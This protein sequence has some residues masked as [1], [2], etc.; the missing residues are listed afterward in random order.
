LGVTT[1]YDP[2][3]P[4]YLDE[5]DV[6]NELTRVFEVCHGCRRCVGYCGSFP[7]L[8]ELVDRL[9][10][11]DPGRLTPAEQDRVVDECFQCK[12]CHVN[13]PYTPDLHEWAIDFPRLML[14][15]EAMRHDT[16]QQP[17]RRRMTTQAM[18]RTDLVGALATRSTPLANAFAGAPTGSLRRKLIAAMTGVS[19]VRLLPTYARQRFST[20]FAQRTPDITGDRGQPVTVYPT[21]V[22]EYQEP[23]IGR[24]LVRVYERNG[25]ECRLSEAG[26]C[27]A[28]WLH[29]GDLD[30]FTKIARTNVATLAAEIRGGGEIVVSQPTCGYVLRRDYPDYVP[31]PDAELVAEHTVDAAEHLVRLHTDDL[32]DGRPGLDLA[33][34]GAVPERITYHAA[35]HLRAQEAAFTS[36]DLLRLVGAEVTTVRQCSGVDGMWGLRSENE[37]TAIPIA[38]RLAN[39]V[40]VAGD[41]PVAGDCHLANTAIAEQTGA[42]PSHPLS[43]I[44]RAYGIPES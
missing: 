37:G 14:R 20:W 32:S 36:G 39:Q 19:A 34:S 42:S 4:A 25:V 26:C 43:V 5:A 22:V 27:G 1:T 18:A 12:L 31:G 15:T 9:D 28:P 8:F 17:L 35:C 38:E 24:D 11:H 33:F 7:T 2:K 23:L 44:A 21:C 41:A 6:R 10:D 3:H 29:A 16:G 13:C 40:A 30:R